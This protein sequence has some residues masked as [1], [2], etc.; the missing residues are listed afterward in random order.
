M[1][2]VVKLGGC[3]GSGKTSVMRELINQ[4]RMAPHYDGRKISA[5]S[6]VSGVGRDVVFLTILGSYAQT[7]GGMDTISNKELV[8]S[9]VEEA[10][11]ART[12]VFM[13]G[14]IVGKTYG[15][16]GALSERDVAEGN[17]WLYAFMDTPFEVCVERVLERRTAKGNTAPFDPERTMRP[18]F[19]G[20]ESLKERV[21]QAGHPVI[22]LDHRRKPATL[23]KNLLNKALEIYN[24]AR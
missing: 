24:A 17:P 3:N 18:T 15:Y 2:T 16:L 1:F 23:A 4:Q 21:K 5:Y 6:G 14:L 22:M 20:I 8:R 12:I 13:E 7:C 9:T 11:Q 19:R 10:R